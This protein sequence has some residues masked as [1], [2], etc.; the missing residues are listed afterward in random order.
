[1]LHRLRQLFRP[2]E[3]QPLP[4]IPPGQRV[5]AVGDIHGRRDLFDALI[6]R[7]ESEDS[8]RGY[9]DTTIVLLG[10]L[11]DRGPD[12]AGV[13]SAA[14]A[15]AARRK[16]R[17]ISGNHEEMFL[18]SFEQKDVLRHFL[19]FG[20]RET[21]LSYPIDM[22]RYQESTLEEAQGLM[23]DA[24]PASDI[25][26]LRDF[27]DYVT[28]GDYLFVHA[29]IR[30]GVA[31]EEQVGADLRWI[32]EPFLSHAADHGQ[33]RLDGAAGAAV[34]PRSRSAGGTIIHDRTCSFCTYSPLR[35]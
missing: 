14:R 17:I 9:A 2:K 12:S 7:I 29:G 5:Y 21:L 10:D 16:V 15:L 8:V 13:I 34:P 25:A 20:G 31:L 18:K 19:R 32:R 30:P 28:I 4:A 1:M 27:E 33:G 11:V 24:I 26:F 22:V 23:R 3:D 6:A 35:A